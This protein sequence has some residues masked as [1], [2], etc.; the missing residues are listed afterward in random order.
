MGIVLHND[1][2]AADWMCDAF[3]H[4]LLSVTINT[5][6]LR[7]FFREWFGAGRPVLPLPVPPMVTMPSHRLLRG[8]EPMADP[9][10]QQ[11]TARHDVL[12]ERRAAYVQA[13]TEEEKS[14]SVVCYEV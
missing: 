9:I 5:K 14:K 4:Q 3:S 8:L 10:L 6:L 12:V 13:I 11:L 7:Q 1:R 2:C